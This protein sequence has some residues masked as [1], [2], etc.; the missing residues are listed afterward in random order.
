MMNKDGSKYITDSSGMDICNAYNLGKCWPQGNSNKC[1]K[2]ARS[3]VCEICQK[4]GHTAVEHREPGGGGKGGGG[5][6]SGYNW[7]PGGGKKSKNGKK[8]GRRS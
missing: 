1:P 7:T 8:Y 4:P 2:G 5:G 6:D 3:H